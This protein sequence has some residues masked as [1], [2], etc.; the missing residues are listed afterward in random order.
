MIE[1]LIRI[2]KIGISSGTVTSRKTPPGTR[3]VSGRRLDKLLR[4]LRQAAKTDQG[5]NGIAPQTTSEVMT[6]QPLH[7]FANQ[8][9]WL[10]FPTWRYVSSQL[11]TPNSKSIIHD[12]TATATT[13]GVAQTKIS[14]PVRSSALRAELGEQ[15][16]DQRAEHHG[17]RDRSGRE[18]ERATTTC[19]NRPSWKIRE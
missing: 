7:V 6:A 18:G 19:Q 9:W 14:P 1:R 8:S 17:Q 10:K 15:E 13:T 11:A 3:A 5:T 16:R 2:T 4:H 12:Q